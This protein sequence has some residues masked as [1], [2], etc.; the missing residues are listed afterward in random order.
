MICVPLCGKRGAGLIAL[1]DEADAHKVCAFKWFLSR[2]GY[3]IANVGK[4]RS[5]R[6][7]AA[8]HRLILDVS[9]G[10]D[11]DHIN[12]SKLDNRR[13]NL[14]TATRSQNNANCGRRSHSLNPFK[15]VRKRDGKWVARLGD[16]HLGRFA[17]AEAAAA[18]YNRA[19]REI[20]GEFAGLNLTGETQ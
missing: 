3:A 7:T 17:T 16:N 19:A 18:A 14:R 6:K 13:S 4:G 15:G 9:P 12:R 2:Q 1:V 8:M 5:G 20:F 10:Q 11:I